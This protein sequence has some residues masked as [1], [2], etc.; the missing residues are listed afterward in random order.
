MNIVAPNVAFFF[1]YPH[2]ESPPRGTAEIEKSD[3]SIT[4][5]GKIQEGE[6]IK[7]LYRKDF[8]DLYCSHITYL[9]RYNDL[10]TF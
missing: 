8:H 10:N 1:R 9:L 3:S 4:D 6:E 2:A 5:F 7:A